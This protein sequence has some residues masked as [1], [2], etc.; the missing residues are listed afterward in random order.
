[1]VRW[2][3]STALT[4]LALKHAASFGEALKA[5]IRLIEAHV[6]PFPC[7]LNE[8]PVN[9][10]FLVDRLHEL[11]AAPIRPSLVFFNEICWMITTLQP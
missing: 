5:R 6:V 3:G 9:K 2:S 7:P 4:K 11:V 10:G 1:M 8:P